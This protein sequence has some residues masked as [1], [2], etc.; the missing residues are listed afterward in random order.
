MNKIFKLKPKVAFFILPKS[1]FIFGTLLIF[2]PK[3]KKILM[4]RSLNYYHNNII[5]K[6]Y[7][8]FLHNFNYCF[9][10]N[11]H[12]AKKDLVEKEYVSNEKIFVINNYIKKTK[13]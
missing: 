8:I 2:F 5:Y 13:L 9:I 7:E 10:C 11:S 6:Y 12:A 4:R 1:Y 3:I